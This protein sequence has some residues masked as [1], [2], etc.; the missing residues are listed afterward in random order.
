MGKAK[1]S[2]LDRAIKALEAIAEANKPKPKKK[3]A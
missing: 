2:R 1:L 3:E